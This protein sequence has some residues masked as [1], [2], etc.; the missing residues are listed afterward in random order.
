MTEQS[1]FQL[2]G[3]GAEAYERYMVPVHC[4]TRAEDLLD[5]VSLQQ[6]AHVLDVGCGSGV[7][8]RFAARRVG[9]GG[10]VTGVELNPDMLNVASRV[11]AI[12]ALKGL[13]ANQR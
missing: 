8:C 9:A 11:S 6:G 1:G 2:E 4:L 13:R 3:T 12:L 10:H 7:V 5:R